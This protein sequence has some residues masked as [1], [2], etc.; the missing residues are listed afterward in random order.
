MQLN[1]SGEATIQY[2]VR[3]SSGQE[4]GPY[5]SFAQATASAA[6]MPMSEGIAPQI[7]PR[8]TQGQQFLLG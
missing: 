8:T 6:T 1:N 5:G 4:I 7:V 3:L 2:Y